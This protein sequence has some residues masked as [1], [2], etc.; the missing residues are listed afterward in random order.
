MFVIST[1]YSLML[2]REATIARPGRTTVVKSIKREL[3]PMRFRSEAPDKSS[4][5]YE[6]QQYY[7]QLSDSDDDDKPDRPALRGDKGNRIGVASKKGAKK[8]PPKAGAGPVLFKREKMVVRERPESA[9]MFRAV[10]QN[11]PEFKV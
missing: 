7:M 4:K 3:V 6:N 9:K 10:A 8:A 2:Q 1:T 5:S 11:D